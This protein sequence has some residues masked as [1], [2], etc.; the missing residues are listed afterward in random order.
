[1]IFVLPVIWRKYPQN[2]TSGPCRPLR[3]GVPYSLPFSLLSNGWNFNC[4]KNLEDPMERRRST[5]KEWCGKSNSS[6]LTLINAQLLIR[7]GIT[8]YQ[9]IP[10][11]LHLTLSS[12]KKCLQQK[13]WIIMKLDQKTISFIFTDL[14]TAT[15]QPHT[16]FGIVFKGF[17]M[18]FFFYC[19]IFRVIICLIYPNEFILPFFLTSVC[20]YM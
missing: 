19:Y 7:A 11:V 17:W 15:E 8:H 20:F 1:M 12:R 4:Q 6:T 14:S 16:I 13:W 5:S 18:I 10:L 9:M 3:A 2:P